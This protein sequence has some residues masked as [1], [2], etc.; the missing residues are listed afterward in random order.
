M[1]QRYELIPK[2]AR[3]KTDFFRVVI[4]W[5]PIQAPEALNYVQA[6]VY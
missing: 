5:Q 4:T 6:K 1:P 3:K 2:R